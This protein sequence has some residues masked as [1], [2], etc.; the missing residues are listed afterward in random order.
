MIIINTVNPPMEELHHYGVKGMKWGV[1]RSDAE[2]GNARLARRLLP[3]S[4][5][6]K[7]A[8]KEK[9]GPGSLEEGSTNQELSKKLQ[10]TPN[11]KKLLVVGGTVVLA[12][13]AAYALNNRK[14][15]IDPELAQRMQE[16]LGRE[17]VEKGLVGDLYGPVNPK[18][19][20]FLS[21]IDHS[22]DVSKLSNKPI[23]LEA[24]SVLKRVSTNPGKKV[25]PNG[26]YASFK[27]DDVERY[28]AV[29]P[30]YW[31]NVWKLG[32][33]EGYVVHL[34]AN[35]PVKA[36]SP[37]KTFEL[38]QEHW[39]GELDGQALKAAASGW[40]RNDDPVTQS[41]FT[42][43]KERGYN[44]VID[45]NDVG[46]YSS[47]PL[48]VIDGSVFSVSKNETLSRG[49]IAL[50]QD[51]IKKLNHMDPKRGGIM[52]IVNT[53]NPPMEELQHY[54]VKGMKWGVRRTEAQ[55][56]SSRASRAKKAAKDVFE[57]KVSKPQYDKAKKDLKKLQKDIWDT[58]DA[59]DS[60][61]RGSKEWKKAN[62]DF[63]SA[64]RAFDE[65][66]SK[67]IVRN[68]RIKQGVV[69][70]GQLALGVAL[71][72]AGDRKVARDYAKI[73]ESG[74]NMAKYGIADIYNENW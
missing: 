10:L 63:E 59:R 37:K 55:L 7:H 28:K 35:S 45:F 9:Y 25:N 38:L 41:F 54:G 12:G 50:A 5:S 48:R 14:G 15:G 42:F 47:A 22:I 30:L 60:K 46:T 39:G 56:A 11:Q 68:V 13:A 2:L 53:A 16:A 71:M 64:V 73:T 43:L 4:D 52:S 17:K 6:K 29:L 31:K 1:R 49:A 58:E 26:F 34:K 23:N 40:S 67:A 44:A 21:N 3:G 8:T 33:E 70:A 32:A 27:D 69:V 62:K 20:D 36:P 51:N 74:K 57:T 65:S 72:K 18:L 61:P 19:H 24:G 66:P